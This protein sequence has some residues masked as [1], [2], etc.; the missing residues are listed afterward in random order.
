VIEAHCPGIER[1]IEWS[2]ALGDGSA[3]PL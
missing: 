1:R 3:A 2:I